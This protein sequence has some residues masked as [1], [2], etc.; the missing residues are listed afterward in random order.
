MSN[1]SEYLELLLNDIIF[2]VIVKHR[3]YSIRLPLPGLKIKMCREIAKI[4][5]HVSTYLIQMKLSLMLRNWYT[6]DVFRALEVR[7]NF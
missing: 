1:F 6:I 4:A 5:T 2:T 3:L 7:N